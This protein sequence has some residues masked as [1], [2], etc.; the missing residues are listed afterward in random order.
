[1]TSIE[2]WEEYAKMKRASQSYERTACEVSPLAALKRKYFCYVAKTKS[3]GV[4]RVQ[5][6][7]TMQMREG[8]T[9]PDYLRELRELDAK[10]FR[11]ELNLIKW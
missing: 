5:T 8:K 7:C 3:K 4:G 11:R 10:A 9:Y 1:M 6:V 2:Y